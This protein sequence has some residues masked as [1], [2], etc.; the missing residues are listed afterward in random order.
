MHSQLGVVTG[1]E[2]IK[3]KG[4]EGFGGCFCCFSCCLFIYFTCSWPFLVVSMEWKVKECGEKSY[5]GLENF[6]C[7]TK[8]EELR[9]MVKLWLTAPTVR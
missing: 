2:N 6:H 9:A 4:I 1:Q 5:L 7:S 8:M 3:E